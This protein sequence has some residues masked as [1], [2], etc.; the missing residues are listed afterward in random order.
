MSKIPATKFEADLLAAVRCNKVMIWFTGVLFLVCLVC[1][2]K[3]P[4]FELASLDRLAAGGL[5]MAIVL[6]GNYN[7]VLQRFRK[8]HE[9]P[10]TDEDEEDEDEEDEDEEYEA[11]N[12]YDS[13]TC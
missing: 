11:K 9:E 2:I 4:H 8:E 7:K 5:A 13:R 3:W 12:A 1:D 10:A 6:H